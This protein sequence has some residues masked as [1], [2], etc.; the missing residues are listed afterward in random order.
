M[1]DTDIQAVETPAPDANVIAEVPEQETPRNEA[2]PSPAAD[3]ADE[4]AKPKG[5]GKRI[6]EL[7]RNWRSAERDRDYWRELAL[8]HQAPQQEVPKP[9]ASQHKT[10]EDFGHDVEQYG[11]YLRQQAIEDARKAA[12]EE[13]AQE[14]ARQTSEQRQTAFQGRETKF[15]KDNPDYLEVTRDPRVPITQQ[16]A[17]VIAESED[18]PAL[19]YHLAKNV[20]IAESIA[21]LPAL[22]Q[23]R[24]L[25]RIEA[26][27]AY[28]RERAAEAKRRVSQAPAPTPKIEATAETPQFRT[29]DASGDALSDEEWVRQERKRISRRK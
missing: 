11:E 28:E 12:R 9:T 15:A 14:R 17:E 21:R 26:R 10:L 23:A 8:K 7:T 24:E 18:G 19:A 20:D 16:M 29:T 4:V 3:D 22:A 1:E 25:G 5:V 13:L 2:D 27:L 6:D